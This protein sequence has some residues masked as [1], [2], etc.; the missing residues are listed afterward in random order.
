[1]NTIY[2]SQNRSKVQ[3]KNRRNRENSDT[4]ERQYMTGHYWHS[5]GSY[6]NVCVKLDLW[7]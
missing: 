7:V 4:L 1:M 5:A 3:P 6:K 2:Q